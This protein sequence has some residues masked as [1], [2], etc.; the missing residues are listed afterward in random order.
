MVESYSIPAWVLELTCKDKSRLD[1]AVEFLRAITKEDRVAVLYDDDGDGMTAAAS[2]VLGLT[3]LVG[4]PPF[5]VKPFEHTPSYIDELLP[6][7]MQA[8][9][10]TK[11]I[12]VD[13]P[14]DQKG[15][16]FLRALEK[17]CPVL[18]I[19]HH[20]I[21]CDYHSPRFTMIKPHI[22]W[23]TE[24]SS[25]PT[26]ILAYTLFS[27]V[28]DLSDKD[29]VPCIGIVSDSSYPRW[30]K[31][32]DASAEKWGL[33]PVKEDGDPFEAPFGILS[34]M[35]YCT[36]ILSSYQM[37]EL[38]DLLIEADH[39]N[40]VLNSGFRAL[41]NVVDEEVKEWMVRLKTSVQLFPEIELALATVQPRH[42]IKSLL[43]N[44]LSRERFSN[45]NLV[46]LQEVAGGT[47]VTL[48]ARRQDFK[49]PMN[50]MLEFAVK[51]MAEAN[52]GGHVP[53]A[54][55]LIRK[56]DEEKFIENVKTFLHAHYS[57][58]PIQ[59]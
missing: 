9:G 7:K 32:V 3:R 46:I 11:I 40:V 21:Y 48:S 54:G 49:V 43:I 25:F 53:A 23:E 19:D 13:K 12:T 47:R 41:V 26:A 56:Q 24:P 18:V 55:G 2:V 50:D 8:E 17:V 20:K 31:M 36:Q 5:W 29:W 1:E 33:E 57:K 35:I 39:P 34:G 51:G 38:L 59:K 42:G 45:W 28:T 30:K 37:P 4:K 44:K 15:E 22:I 6:Q 14:I 27:M 10:I 16:V 52:A 58:N